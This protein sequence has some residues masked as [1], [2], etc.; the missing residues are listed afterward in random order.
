MN[1]KKSKKGLLFIA[2]LVLSFSLILVGCDS[3]KVQESEDLS[4][5]VENDE[6][7]QPVSGLPELSEEEEN[8]VIAEVNSEEILYKDFYSIYKYTMD[9]N[10]MDPTTDDEQV[11][12]Q[13]DGFKD[14]LFEDLIYRS[15]MRQKINE[16]GYE[17]TDEIMEDA[18]EEYKGSIEGIAMQMQMQGGEEDAG[19]DYMQEAEEYVLEQIAMMN[20]T[21]DSYIQDIAEQILVNNYINDLVED[22]EASEE[23]LREYYDEQLEAQRDGDTGGEM[24]FMMPEQPQEVELIEPAQTRVKHVLIGISEEARDEYMGLMQGG[25]QEAAE[26]FL[27]E[28]LEEIK[29]KAEEVLDKARSGED[30]EELIAEYGEDPGMEQEPD[31]YSVTKGSQFV[32]EFEEASLNL[33]EGEVSDLVPT[34]HGYHIIKAYEKIEESVF[35]FEE[36]RDEIKELLDEKEQDRVAEETIDS[37]VEEAEI[38]KYKENI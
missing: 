22:V 26:S 37:W 35:D 18:K 11:L 10:Q 29:P 1:L 9:S 3:D 17:V 14:E 31:G 20:Q 30:F 23:A 5:E 19:I 38:I 16:D 25:D 33:E 8:V 27:E 13:I 21:K 7:E 36:K 28:K 2:V 15:V 34:M 4:G 32:P 12:A 24:D 6:L